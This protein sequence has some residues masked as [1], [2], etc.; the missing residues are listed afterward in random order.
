MNLGRMYMMGVDVVSVGDALYLSS[1]IQLDR[2]IE[3]PMH[4]GATCGAA[5]AL[6][7]PG[8]LWQLHRSNRRSSGSFVLGEASELN[9]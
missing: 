8:H 4:K 7:R 3:V 9:P 6:R 1:T 5:A 2:A